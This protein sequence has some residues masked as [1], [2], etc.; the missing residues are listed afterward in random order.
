VAPRIWVGRR[1]GA[2]E[3]PPDTRLV[4]DLTCEMWCP[5]GVGD[6]RRYVC[7]PTLD[8]TAP[9][10]AA[11]EALLRHA[12]DE[13]GVIYI[14]C[15]QGRGRS[16]ALAAALLIARGTA[17]DVDQAE[18]TLRKARPSVRLNPAQ[19][20]WVARLIRASA[21]VT[22][23]FLAAIV[24]TGCA[25]R[26]QASGRAHLTGAKIAFEPAPI[27]GYPLFNARVNGRPARFA[28]DTGGGRAILVSQALVEAAKLAVDSGAEA[29]LNGRAYP[30]AQIRSL[31]VEGQGDVVR[32]VSA[33]VVSL[34]TF[35]Q[36]CGERVDGIIG[37]EAFANG[38]GGSFEI[39]FP[40]HRLRLGTRP[41]GGGD[42]VIPMSP[43]PDPQA[44]RRPFVWLQVG[45]AR[46]PAVIDS[47]EYEAV[48][49]P[50]RFLAQS[51]AALGDARASVG[52]SGFGGAI[53]TSRR[54]RLTEMR[55][56]GVV[57]RDAEVQ[58]VPS[59]EPTVGE[60]AVVGQAIV[61]HYRVAFDASTGS[62][63]FFGP[64]ELKSPVPDARTVQAAERLLAR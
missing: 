39:D 47:C 18:A 43:V 9:G 25:A 37:A 22:V 13:T 19:R 2:W 6:D 56:G 11:L 49:L 46:V 1:A 24:V 32:E 20:A 62:V 45:E 27:S 23:L 63:T 15:A 50:E 38:S 4:V 7:L 10:P 26:D 14:H 57:I 12:R 44:Q 59:T 55:L 31:N 40:R 28:F 16:A 30:S 36:L 51:G 61:R 41:P 58:V 35:S 33:A 52:S 8:G 5:R 60:K 53:R 42:E 21:A 17:A 64:R 54:G 48:Q 34:E 3:L 29:R